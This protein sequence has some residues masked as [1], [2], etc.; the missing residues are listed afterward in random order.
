MAR[1]P[2]GLLRSNA[3]LG[4][5]CAALLAAAAG[6][7]AEE[8]DLNWLDWQALEDRAVLVRTERDVKPLTVQVEIAAL[9]TA[10]PE[11][12]WNILTACQIAPEYVPNVTNCRSSLPK[13]RN[14]GSAPPNRS[15]CGG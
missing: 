9:V 14:A 5:L 4:L 11:A 3:H 1:A 7:A 15:Q 13:A 2:S 8:P 10:A 6:A 12:I